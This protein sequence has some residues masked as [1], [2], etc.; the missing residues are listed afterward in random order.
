VQPGPADGDRALLL[1][2]LG[3]VDDVVGSC[4]FHVDGY[5]TNRARP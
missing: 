5:R 2:Q 3:E 4:G 1:A